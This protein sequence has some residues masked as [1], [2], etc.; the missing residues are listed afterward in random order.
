MR[1]DTGQVFKLED[2]RP[3]D[4]LIPQTKLSFNLSPDRTTVVSELA[5]ERNAETGDGEPLVLDGDGLRLVDL[6]IDGETLGPNAY[7]VTPEKL[8]IHALPKGKT[9]RLKITTE[10]SPS[11]NTALMG[12]YRSNGVY[13]T[14]CEA[15]GF[16]RITYFLDR[17]DILSVYTVRI[18]ADRAE[19]PLLLTV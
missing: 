11:T 9:F 19:A 12:L 2:Y 10:I 14:Q 13:C 1:T 8:T 4:F 16:R 17:P 18:E 6:E 5:I 3:S 7:E 15:E